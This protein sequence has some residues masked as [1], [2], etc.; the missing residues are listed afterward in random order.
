[1]KKIC[2][3]FQVH[4]PYRLRTYRFFDIGKKHDYFD[5]YANRKILIK[6]AEK[7]YLPTNQLLL[8]LI[9]K[10]KGKFKICFSITGTLLDQ[11]QLVV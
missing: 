10:H 1:M 4:Q 8:E 2:F 5:D 9:E 6:V 7:C 3:Y 11:M